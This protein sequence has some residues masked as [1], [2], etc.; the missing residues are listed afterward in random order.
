MVSLVNASDEE[1]WV[2]IQ[3]RDSAGNVK[4]PGLGLQENPDLP[5]FCY[6]FY[7]K[8][9]EHRVFLPSQFWQAY[10]PT[11]QIY[12]VQ[13]SIKITGKLPRRGGA[14]F[15]VPENNLRQCP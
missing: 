6:E 2:S 10:S 9:H 8:P 12:D 15:P 5:H 1:D 4:V 3:V 7:M 11:S 14:E 13:G